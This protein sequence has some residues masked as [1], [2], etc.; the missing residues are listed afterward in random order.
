MC[1]IVGFQDVGA[2]TYNRGQAIM[3]MTNVL[4]RGGPDHGETVIEQ[5]FCFGH[6][7]LSILDLNERSNQPFRWNG[8]II[9]FNGE[10]YN[11]KEIKLSLEDCGYLFSTTSDTEVVIKAYH[12]WGTNSF[13]MFRGMFA[14]A[15][16]DEREKE[17]IL[18]RDRVGVKPLYFYMNEAVFMFASETKAFHSHPLFR[19]VIDQAAVSE[20][21]SKGFLNFQSSIFK[22]VEKLAPGSYAI[23]K[24]GEIKKNERFWE[25]KKIDADEKMDEADAANTLEELLKESI[26]LR[27][28]SDVPVGIF[29]SG[30]ID[31][32]TLVGFTRKMGVENINTFTI[33]FENKDFDES[34]HA[35]KVADF[36]GYKNY[37]YSFNE[38]DLI[39]QLDDFVEAYDEPFADASGLPTML[40]SKNTREHVKVAL[41]ADGGDELFGGYSRYIFLKQYGSAIN[42]IPAGLKKSAAFLLD[43]I[44][45]N[46][47]L[48]AGNKVFN[49]TT[50]F[51][52]RFKKL[53]S[54]L[55][56]TSIEDMY[57]G[58]SSM[59]N[60]RS[61]SKLLYNPAKERSIIFSNAGSYINDAGKIDIETYLE[62]DILAKVDRASMYYGL[63]AREPLL[64]NKLIEFALT[65]PDSLKFKNGKSK[66]L[67]RK[68]L[69]EL[70]PS[71]LFE[72]PKQGFVVPIEKWLKKNL[73]SELGGYLNDNRMFVD[74][75]L[76]QNYLR[77]IYHSD[78]RFRKNNTLFWNF[79]V[80]ARWYNRWY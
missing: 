6:R 63:E 22:G 58:L 19:K 16:Y 53:T 38:E 48:S 23:L 17:L 9:I 31:S 39:N 43:V 7:R 21:L 75:G 32:S 12:K 36:F 14:F 50:N 15:I 3:N 2:S 70:L 77:S 30:G 42:K 25:Y 28:V 74:L 55:S 68:K 37:Q 73:K 13:E 49:K 69:A 66:F 24:N 54:A 45:P 60:K 59:N 20:F 67:L 35:R 29:L 18:C 64:D 78:Y 51:E 11:F 33:G 57:S 56:S 79:Y 46:R 4:T 61:I 52:N 72:R 26:N 80:L 8:L 40:L 76:N 27:L 34:E 10:V 5:D 44:P 1:R 71:S 47:L 62:G 41:S 65:I